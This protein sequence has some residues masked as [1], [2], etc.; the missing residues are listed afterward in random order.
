[1]KRTFLAIL[2]LPLLGAGIVG[3]LFP[4]WFDSPALVW[5]FSKSSFVVF[6]LVLLLAAAAI[7]RVLLRA[8]NAIHAQTAAVESHLRN[9][10]DE[11]VQDS[12][13]LEGFLRTD[14]PQMEE[15][16]KVSK[17]TLPKEVFSSY[18]SIWTRI[19]T[20]AEAAFRDLENLPLEPQTQEMHKKRSEIIL[21]YKDLLNRHTRAKTILERVRADLSLLKERLKERNC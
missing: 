9:I 4:E 15:R 2:V 19:R 20:D 10:L 21:E 17:E 14:L 13:A 11:L 5:L 8:R 7:L 18:H 12:Q 3:V 6:L 1:M 16:L